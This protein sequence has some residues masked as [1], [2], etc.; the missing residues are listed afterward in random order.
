ML[1]Q[2]L[3]LTSFILISIIGILHVSAT[4]FYLYWSIPWFDNLMHFLGGLW[5]GTTSIWFFFFSGY[6][7]KF[8]PQFSTR[9]IL[10]VSI[11]SVIVI[12]VLWEFFEIGVGSVTLTETDY[13]IDTSVDLLMDTLG[14]VVA[15]FYAVWRFKSN[16]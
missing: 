8:T 7:G 12:G 13:A 10:T 4:E 15:S 6:A 9:N 2:P 1:K 5:F 14:A 16:R 3:F 11:A